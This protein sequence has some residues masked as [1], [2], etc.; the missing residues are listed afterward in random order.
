MD[1]WGEGEGGGGGG[2]VRYRWVDLWTGVWG[3]RGGFNGSMLQKRDG[4]SR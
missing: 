4:G 2:T 1:V 3:E